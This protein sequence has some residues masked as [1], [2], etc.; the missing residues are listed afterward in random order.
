MAIK[1][2][3]IRSGET[4]TADT[5]PMISAFYNS[6]DQHVNAM[7]G[8]DMG[9]RLAKETVARIR[10]I[11]NNQQEL[12]RIAQAFQL[13]MG[14]VSE[15]DILWWI[16]L[17]DARAEAQANQSK[18]GDFR[19]QYE[20]EIRSLDEESSKSDSAADTG[21]AKVKAPSTNDSKEKK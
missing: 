16:S 19:K 13:P 21:S 1:F 6:T 14:E 4:R 17:Q 11:Q 8:Q 20:A 10:E 3:N 7:V 2:F 9:W 12:D 5:E 18:Q 15:T